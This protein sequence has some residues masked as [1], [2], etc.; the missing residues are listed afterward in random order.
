MRKWMVCDR[1][2][3]YTLGQGT[4]RSSECHTNWWV[5]PSAATVP[6]FSRLRRFL[7]S[8]VLTSTKTVA[9]SL[10]M[11]RYCLPSLRLLVI[12]ILII[13]VRVQDCRVQVTCE[14][15]VAPVT[16]TLIQWPWC[17][18]VTFWRFW[19]CAYIWH[20]VY[21]VHVSYVFTYHCCVCVWLQT[22]EAVSAARALLEFTEQTIEL[23]RDLICK[24]LLFAFTFDA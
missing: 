23:P 3:V 20:D 21:I 10:C 19:R 8:A 17:T 18:H 5:S 15:Y 14:C 1:V 12:T 22:Q 2:P 9:R 13:T 11:A 4:A 6:T 24:L 16:S 7:V